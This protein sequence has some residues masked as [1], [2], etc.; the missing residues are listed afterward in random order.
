MAVFSRLYAYEEVP[1]V[2]ETCGYGKNDNVLINTFFKISLLPDF[3]IMTKDEPGDVSDLGNAEC[4]IAPNSDSRTK[5]IEILREI[6]YDLFYSEYRDEHDYIKRVYIETDSNG[7]TFMLLAIIGNGGNDLGAILY[8]GASIDVYR[9][10]G[11]ALK[12]NNYEEIEEA[13]ISYN[14]ECPMV[15]GPTIEIT[16]MSINHEYW[17]IR[18][19]VNTFGIGLNQNTEDVENKNRAMSA[20]KAFEK[21]HVSKLF[22]LRIGFKVVLTSETGESLSIALEY[23]DLAEIL[24]DTD[25]S[26]E[27]VIEEFVR[28]NKNQCPF[29][30]GIGMIMTDLKLFEDL[31][32]IELVVDENVYSIDLMRSNIAE[33]RENIANMIRLK[34]DLLIE[35]IAEFLVQT[36]R[37][38]GYLYTGDISNQAVIVFLRSEELRELLNTIAE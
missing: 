36:D 7:N 37:G 34:Q 23:E 29:D 9:K 33:M 28:N 31:L 11:D 27:Q 30:I 26:P 32:V 17:T 24:N 22:N 20:L 5:V 19:K 18:M 25:E 4:V 38:F 1:K 8:R 10:A 15:L 16:S 6:P 3:T 35:T 13:V 12:E 21:Y 14:A 2:L